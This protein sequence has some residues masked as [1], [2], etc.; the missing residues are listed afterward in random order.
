NTS[1][2]SGPTSRLVKKKPAWW[3]V[4]TVQQ[5]SQKA[6]SCN[7]PSSP[8]S[9]QMHASSK[10]KSS[11]QSS[12]LPRSTPTK[13]P[14]NLPTTLLTVWPHTFG[15][16]TCSVH[17]TSH[18]KLMPV[19]SGS[20]PTTSATCAPHS[21]VSRLPDSV[22]KVATARSTSTPISKQSTSTLAKSTTQF[23]ENNSS[24]RCLASEPKDQQ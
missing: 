21:V 18:K 15:P 17:T 23:S 5:N 8:T 12:Q 6:T 19:W 7:Q 16:T 24:K 4:V 9:H 14:W 13:K 1:K 20:T 3:P 10:K 22:R 11:A 2:K